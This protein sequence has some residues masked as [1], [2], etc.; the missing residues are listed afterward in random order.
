METKKIQTGTSWAQED[1]SY[2]EK[3]RLFD[4]EVKAE[5]TAIR[6]YNKS[7]KIQELLKDFI[8]DAEESVLAIQLQYTKNK[9]PEKADLKILATKSFTFYCFN[10]DVR[11]EK[12]VQNLTGYKEEDIAMSKEYFKK[13]IEDIK[14]PGSEIIVLKELV[15]SAFTTKSGKFDYKK[16]DALLGYK[17]KIK[18]ETFQ[19]AISLLAD[20]KYDKKMKT[21]FN[22]YF[23]AKDGNYEQVN[24]RLSGVN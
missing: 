6:L 10:R 2:V 24:L 8:A 18:N 4:H 21:Y 1:G 16:L 9:A 22:V 5:R 3:K 15:M 20:A 12:I 7:A 13:Y 11:V 19:K 17:D 23:R 14:D